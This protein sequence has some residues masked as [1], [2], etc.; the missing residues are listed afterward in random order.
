M[1]DTKPIQTDDAAAREPDADVVKK[2]KPSDTPEAPYP[3]QADLDAIKEGK[4]HK[5]KRD[6]KADDEKA[7]YKTR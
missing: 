1:A 5:N 4:F 7:L 2:G 3:S 6:L